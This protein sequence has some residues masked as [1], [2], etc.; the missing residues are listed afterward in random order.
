M[1]SDVYLICMYISAANKKSSNYK[2]LTEVRIDYGKSVTH[3]DDGEEHKENA[4]VAA[5]Q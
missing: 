3:N 4:P 5:R 2:R 1:L